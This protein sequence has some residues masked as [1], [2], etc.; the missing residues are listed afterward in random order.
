[1]SDR[2]S[3]ELGLTYCIVDKKK[4]GNINPKVIKTSNGRYMLKSKC[5]VC[6]NIKTR[7]VKAQEASGLLSML[8]VNTSGK[9]AWIKSAVLTRAL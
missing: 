6:G 2:V 9:G 1:M 3:K 4:T 5:A 8:G 7:F